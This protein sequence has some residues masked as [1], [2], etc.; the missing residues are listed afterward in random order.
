MV[1]KNIVPKAW[2]IG[3]TEAKGYFQLEK[4]SDGKILH[5]IGR[6]SCRERV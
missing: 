6:A 1:A 2:A 3:F 4:L 5:K